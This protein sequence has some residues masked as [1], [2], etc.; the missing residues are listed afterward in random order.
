MLQLSKQLSIYGVTTCVQIIMYTFVTVILFFAFAGYTI[1]PWLFGIAGTIMLFKV[2]STYIK[3]KFIEKCA[4]K[5]EIA[6]KS[7]DKSQQ[8]EMQYNKLVDSLNHIV[9]ECENHK[10]DKSDNTDTQ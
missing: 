3:F 5:F 8:V 10:P 7:S 2:I 6:V 9:D 1:S 4:T